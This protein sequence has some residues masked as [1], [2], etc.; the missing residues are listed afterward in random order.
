MNQGASIP[1]LSEEEVLSGE[2][3][4]LEEKMDLHNHMIER[5]RRTSFAN[6]NSIGM[7]YNDNGLAILRPHI[8]DMNHPNEKM[9]IAS[10]HRRAVVPP[11]N[12]LIAAAYHEENT[13]QEIPHVQTQIIEPNTRMHHEVRIEREVLARDGVI[14]PSVEVN[15]D[16]DGYNRT[17]LYHG[18]LNG[19]TGG[20]CGVSSGT[21]NGTI[22][23]S[24]TI[25]VYTQGGPVSLGG[26]L[27]W[28][29][30][31]MIGQQVTVSAIQTM[32]RHI[33]VTTGATM[34]NVMFDD[35]NLSITVSATS[36]HIILNYS[37][38]YGSIV[39]G[40]VPNMAIHRADLIKNIMKSNL[41]IKVKEKMKNVGINSV[42]LKARDT[43][44]D[45][46]TEREWRRYVT[47]GFIMVKGSPDFV[48][49]R[50]M[51]KVDRDRYNAELGHGILG[52]L[53]G[54]VE[55]KQYRGQFWYQI[56]GDKRV[57][58][59]KDNKNIGELCIH[60]DKICPP[61]DHVIN[62]KILVE[63]DEQAIWTGANFYEKNRVQIGNPIVGGI[64][65]V[66]S[67]SD[68]GRILNLAERWKNFT[69]RQMISA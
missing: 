15:L 40:E 39:V 7:S 63:L 64:H 52:D 43:L 6:D 65:G 62:M 61:T 37:T 26:H 29:G 69:Q 18:P 1:V 13:P 9:V 32:Q 22:T 3:I 60:S 5:R 17:N 19:I 42:E 34:S 57:Q 12:G 20:S 44:R 49:D 53:L 24:S 21:L 8:F 36:D 33:S 14:L 4:P 23:D 54:S 41:V 30:T 45:M 31:S 46:I 47:N 56:F 35:N 58:V 25:T 66:I 38:D 55:E 10:N 68:D 28:L 27:G 2:R 51:K 11:T 67:D 48:F 16:E 59:F 50:G